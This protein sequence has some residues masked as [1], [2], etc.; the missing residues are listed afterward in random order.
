VAVYAVYL[1]EGVLHEDPRETFYEALMLL[2]QAECEAQDKGHGFVRFA[3]RDERDDCLWSD[4]H[5]SMKT[6][7]KLY[8]SGKEE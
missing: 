4:T 3:V 1:K 2:R 5:V 6:I 8:P 7:R